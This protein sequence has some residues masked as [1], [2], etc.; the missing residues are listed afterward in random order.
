M[1]GGTTANWR[2]PRR[3]RSRRI[4]MTLAYCRVVAGGFLPALQTFPRKRLQPMQSAYEIHA[5]LAF[6]QREMMRQSLR[7]R[8]GRRFWDGDQIDACPDWN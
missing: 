2:R 8:P 1:L 6:R 4:D 7:Q 5:S 3:A